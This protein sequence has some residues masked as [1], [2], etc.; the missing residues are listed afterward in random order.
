MEKILLGKY[1]HVAG[2]VYNI[3]LDFF[4][5]NLYVKLTITQSIL[6]LF[7]ILNIY[8]SKKTLN[9]PLSKLL[10]KFE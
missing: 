7:T 1:L 10:A 8:R 5:I 2:E 4:S 6:K 9:L 3:K